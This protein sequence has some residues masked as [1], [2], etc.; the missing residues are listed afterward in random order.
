MSKYQLKIW[1]PRTNIKY[2]RFFQGVHGE[3]RFSLCDAE[4]YP[5]HTIFYI[6]EGEKGFYLKLTPFEGPVDG[7][8]LSSYNTI[9]VDGQPNLENT[10]WRHISECPKEPLFIPG[11]SSL[12]NMGIS[13]PS[14]NT[15]IQ[16]GPPFIAF[17]SNK[18][19]A[20]QVCWVVE[21]WLTEPLEKREWIAG[22]PDADYFCSFPM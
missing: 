17:D 8:W 3:F 11:Q 12:T 4:G 19:Q 6:M 16:F 18:K 9:K 21:T 20:R 10:H 2:L 14:P 13:G 5:K 15:K 22:L 7:V 1:D